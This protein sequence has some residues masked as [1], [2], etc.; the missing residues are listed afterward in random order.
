MKEQKRIEAIVLRKTGQTINEISK[1]L[2]V[3]KSSVSVWVRNIILSELATNKINDKLSLAQ[4]RS[5]QA[6]FS[7]TAVKEADAKK[8]AEVI[9]NNLKTNKEFDCLLCAMIYWCEGNKSTHDAVS[10]TNSD[11]Q[12]LMTFL[13]LFRSSFNLD[14]KKFRVC[15]HLH[16]YHNDNEQLKFW[17]KTLRIPARQFTKTFRKKNI[18]IY[19]KEGYQ[20]CVRVRYQDVTI[21]RKL[22]ATARAFM[23]KLGP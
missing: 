11:P 15:M 14:E 19:K 17:S 7:K 12:L 22:L 3:S 4:Q 16:N 8:Y 5:R 23:E 21:A 10:F 13:S 20:G 18:G 9:I 6:I 2:T 1:I